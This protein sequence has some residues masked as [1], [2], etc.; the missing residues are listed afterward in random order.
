MNSVKRTRGIR[1]M[2][3]A[4]VTGKPAPNYVTA[5]DHSCGRMMQE[6]R[7]RRRSGPSD[8][9]ILAWARYDLSREIRSGFWELKA[10]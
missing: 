7:F 4:V 5:G 6:A 8:Q 9:E 3:R 2:L 1:R 10:A